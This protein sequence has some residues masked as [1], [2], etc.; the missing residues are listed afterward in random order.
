MELSLKVLS[1]RNAGQ[2]IKVPVTKFIIGRSEDCH[3]RPHSDLVSRHHCALLIDNGTV[4]IRDFNS[5]NGTFVNG[6]K[7]VGQCDLKSG[8]KVA[9]GQLVF[10]VHA[11]HGSA[12]GH[13]PKVKGV[14]DVAAR[15]ASSGGVDEDTDVSRWLADDTSVTSASDTKSSEELAKTRQVTA[16]E[17]AHLKR[18]ETNGEDE[19]VAAQAVSDSKAGLTDGKSS[20]FKKTPGKLPPAPQSSTKDSREAAAEMLKKI[21]RNR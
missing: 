20:I 19:T 18:S 16:D 14:H 2:V 9:V 7:V 21:L 11:A 3:L 4:A 1:G 13:K 8:D 17:L 5:K 6:E 15:T 12:I 10:E